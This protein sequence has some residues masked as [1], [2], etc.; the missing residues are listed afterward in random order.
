MGQAGAVVG[1]IQAGASLF[2]GSGG[3]GGTQ[4]VPNNSAMNQ[5]QLA[6]IDLLSRNYDMQKQLSD[7]AFQ[8]NLGMQDAEYKRLLTQL[9]YDQE[10]QHNTLLSQAYQSQAATNAAETTLEME[11]LKQVYDRG[12]KETA[13][14]MEFDNT[15]TQIDNQ[16]TIRDLSNASSQEEFQR[17]LAETQAQMGDT[18]Q[19]RTLQTQNERLQRQELATQYQALSTEERG[20]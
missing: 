10:A 19:M 8:N 6:S 5:V 12:A 18:R 13:A 14:K 9:A 20:L 17:K 2:G 16:E 7:A 15:M 3:S 1:V 11:R 4:Y